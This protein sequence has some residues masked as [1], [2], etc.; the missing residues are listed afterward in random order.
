VLD[1]LRAIAD[2][3]T[4]ADSFAH[5]AATVASHI[6][7]EALSEASLEDLRLQMPGLR[8]AGCWSMGCAR[9]A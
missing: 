3:T 9:A 7:A 5:F 2:H 4:A 1:Q 6:A 8:P